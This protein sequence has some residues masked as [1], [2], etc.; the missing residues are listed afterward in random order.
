MFCHA[1]HYFDKAPLST[2]TPKSLGEDEPIEPPEAYVKES[3]K[4][5]R[6]QILKHYPG[7]ETKVFSTDAFMALWI[8]T[9]LQ[10]CTRTGENR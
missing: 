1:I 4:E 8:G 3:A 2:V 5:L 10:E 7:I 9:N 6:R